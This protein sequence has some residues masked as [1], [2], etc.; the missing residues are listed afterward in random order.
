MRPISLFEMSSFL[1]ELPIK[2]PYHIWP[3]EEGSRRPS[4]IRGKP[5]KAVHQLSASLWVSRQGPERSQK[6]SVLHESVS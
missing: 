1:I 3:L 6:L 4:R 5:S 2:Q